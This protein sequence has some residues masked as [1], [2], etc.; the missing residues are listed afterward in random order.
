MSNILIVGEAW[1]EDE[2]YE[3]RSFASGL[4]RLFKALM[5]QVGIVAND[6]TFTSVFNQR[7]PN[8]D[9]LDNFCGEKTADIIRG[10][11]PLNKGKY[12]LASF[13]HHLTA[14]HDLIDKE[15]PNIIVAAGNAALWALCKQTGL[16]KVRGAPTTT[17]IRGREYKVIATYAPITV[18]RQWELR[19]IVMSDLSKAR[20]ESTF[21]E[22]IRP[23]RM[24]WVEPS[25][26]DMLRFEEEHINPSHD[27]SIDIE[28]SIEQITCI[29]FAPAIDLAIVIPI[30]DTTKP[31][32]NYWPTLEEE[33][34]VWKIIR[35]WCGLP[36]AIVGQNF[37]Y[38]IKFLLAKYGIPLPGTADD[39][40]L[41]HHALQ[42]EME[43][44]LGFLG[45]IYTKEASWK[46]MR[47]KHDTIKKED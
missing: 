40:M 14:L 39:T 19:M 47:P 12:V 11:P 33:I 4:G 18:R 22:L 44:G 8:N 29:G 20:D 26:A 3:Q 42:P 16:K 15:R 38:D 37:Q 23:E 5:S 1:G 24:I 13:E 27:L 21:S 46:F 17:T 36:K 34:E 32:N 10:Y 35:R 41:L 25:I 31:G 9:Q 30:F 43:K 28:T 6:C 45:S 7:P 2:A